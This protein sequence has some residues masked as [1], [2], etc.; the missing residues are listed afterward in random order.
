MKECRKKSP[1]NGSCSQKEPR[2]VV[3][4]G[5]ESSAFRLK[6][7]CV[8]RS[9]APNNISCQVHRVAYTQREALKLNISYVNCSQP[10]QSQRSMSSLNKISALKVH[11]FQLEPV[12]WCCLLYSCL[13]Q[14][15]LTCR[16][17][18]FRQRCRRSEDGD[19]PVRKR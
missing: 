2:L 4:I 15:M 5:D 9:F 16:I 1:L 11:G 12:F 8:H 13:R 7:L 10:G 18:S 14:Q 6:T 17:D 3:A 19:C